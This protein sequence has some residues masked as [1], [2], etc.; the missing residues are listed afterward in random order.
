[1]AGAM[2]SLLLEEIKNVLRAE[3]KSAVKKALITGVTTDSRKVQEGDLFIALHGERFDGHD[4]LKQA[5]AGGARGLVIDRNVPLPAEVKEKGVGVLKVDDTLAALG[6]LARFYRRSLGHGVMV[7]GVTGSNGK[8]TT[9]EMIYHVLSKYRKGH[10][11][12]ENFN[13][14]IGVPVTLLGVENEDDFVVV[15]MGSNAPGEI[16]ALSRIAEPDIAV[17]TN[18]GPSHLA[19]FKDLK[20]VSV[21]KVSI[22]AGLKKHG[23]VICGAGHTDTLERLRALDWNVITFGVDGPADVTGSKVRQEPGRLYFETNDR[24][25]VE[26]PI[27]GV[28]NVKNA[29]AALAVVRR[30]GI[31]S[32]QYAE[33]MKDFGGVPGRM[34]GKEIHGI[35]V[36][37]DSYNAN[38]ASMSAAIAELSTWAGASRRVL[39]CGD[40]EE[41]GE[42]AAEYHV[43]LG[44]EVARSNIDILFAVGPKCSLAANAA[45]EAGMGHSR[46]QK[47]INSRR[48]ARLIKSMIREGDVI[49]VKGSHAM[50]MEKVVESLGRFRGDRSGK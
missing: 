37:D 9:R 12:P 14:Q 44:E 36:I 41:L 47:S 4:F 28:H 18:V 7:I 48:L 31:T 46:V 8:T 10:R 3:L 39:V 20:G 6:N 40:M 34:Q 15:E 22:V 24:V 33:A 30:M 25:K 29:L 13:N 16:A 43:Q 11:S 2:K 17:I 26:I 1:M 23:V 19:G 5:V 42:T 50:Q 38:P 45:M 21:E 49:L 32:G 27:M 35:T